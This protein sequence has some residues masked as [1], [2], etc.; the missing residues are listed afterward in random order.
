MMDLDFATMLI[1]PPQKLALIG[2][3]P[4]GTG[5][6]QLLDHQKYQKMMFMEI[7]VMQQQQA[8]LMAHIQRC[9]ERLFK[10]RFVFMQVHMVAFVLGRLKFKY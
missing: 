2:K 6:V 1:L 10:E 8:G 7:I 5:L 3:D 9:W 4:G